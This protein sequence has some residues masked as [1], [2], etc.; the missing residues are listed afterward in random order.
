MA[1]WH[2]LPAAPSRPARGIAYADSE[3]DWN[4]PAG[5][6]RDPQGLRGS[7]PHVLSEASFHRGS[8]QATCLAVCGGARWTWRR[9]VG[10]HGLFSPT[11]APQTARASRSAS[12]ARRPMPARRR[13]FFGG[14]FRRRVWRSAGALGA[15]GV[16]KS[17]SMGFSRRRGRCRPPGRRVRPPELPGR[18]QHFSASQ[19]ASRQVLALGGLR[20]CPGCAVA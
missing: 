5:A 2:R 20:R 6:S 14:R 10:D 16:V 17:G 11:R 15:R 7:A 9:H 12:G 19:G 3:A 13:R 8:V 4:P 18:C 1:L